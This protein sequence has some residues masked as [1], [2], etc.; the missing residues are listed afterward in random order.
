MITAIQ[1][2]R[3]KIYIALFGNITIGSTTLA[4]YN[5][6][7]SNAT[8]PFIKIYSENE[9]QSNLN[10][11]NFITTVIT[12]IEIVARYS[13]NAG[14]ELEVQQ[15]VSQILNILK[16]S[17]IGNYDLSADD[18]N[19]VT[20]RVNDVTYLSTD[21]KDHYYQRAIIELENIVEQI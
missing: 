1:H 11:T 21:L 19:S 3:K 2:I 14:G 13:G 17:I 7:P 9:E 16:S 18:L 10:N 12:K 20:S 6:V 15:A 8:Y 5:R 4:V